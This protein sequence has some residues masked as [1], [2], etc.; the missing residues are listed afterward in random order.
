MDFL[1]LTRLCALF[2]FA[3]YVGRKKNPHH[4]LSVYK[5][6]SKNTGDLA[7]WLAVF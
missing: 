4:K 5:T 6:P 7:S 3:A 1:A 2:N